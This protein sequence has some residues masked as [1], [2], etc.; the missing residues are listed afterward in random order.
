MRTTPKGLAP[1]TLLVAISVLLTTPRPAHALFHFAW[2]DEIMT[3]Y[4]CDDT[5]Q[6]VEI[7]MLFPSQNFVTN[8]VLGAF[9]D[10]GAYLGDV[11][12][13]P[14][15]V[16]IGGVD[17]RW[18]MGTA[19]FQTASGVAP[20]FIIPAVLP[21]TGGMICWGAPGISPPNPATWDHTVPANYVDC[22]AYGTYSGPTNIRSG[23]PTPLDGIGHSLQRIM[24]SNNSVDDFVCAEMATPENNAGAGAIL[25]ATI[26]CS[27][28]G[29][30]S[31]GDGV[32]DCVDNC[33]FV[34]NGAGLPLGQPTWGGQAASAQYPGVGCA[35]LCGDP[36]RDCT[37]NVGD[38]P[39]A[40][41]AGLVPPLAPLSPFFDAS[42]CD[43]NGD[44][45]CNVGDS[46]E[47]QRAGLVPALPP[48]SPN[49][50][51]TGC[52]GYLG[53]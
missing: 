28:A 35:C 5:V 48:L 22:V 44:G 17:V 47:M 3:S 32:A 20:D 52:S 8:S 9:D 36:N 26:S 16:P 4:G 27:G 11:L 23:T 40:Q 41:R 38:A 1:L 2:I 53:P 33:P 46:P 24:D 39:E 30:D 15:D 14:A 42:F 19:A 25:G 13:V 51:V 18:I 6:F 7:K 49:F 34:A 31:D 43:L 37:V 50:D 21:T 45:V 29:A 12:V 10:S